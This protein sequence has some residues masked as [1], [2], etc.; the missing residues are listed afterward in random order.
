ERSA[1]HGTETILVAE[2]SDLVR[3]LTREMLEMRGYNVIEAPN[4]EDALGICKTYSGTFHLLLSDVVMPGMNGRELAEKAV[5]LR[6][7]MKVLLMSGYAGEISRAGFLH[8]G[9]HFIEKPFTSNA[10]AIKVREVLDQS[11]SY[12]PDMRVLVTADY[13]TLS[14]TAAE[15]V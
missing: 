1:P 6:P 7:D 15:L 13:R 11:E 12:S 5:R 10:L 4:G 3:Q 8:P 9:L 2:D 14:E